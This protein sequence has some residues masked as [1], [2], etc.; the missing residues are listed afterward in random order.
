MYTIFSKSKIQVK[1]WQSTKWVHRRLRIWNRTPPNVILIGA[2]IQTT[3]LINLNIRRCNL[4]HLL[5]ELVI[6]GLYWTNASFQITFIDLT[7]F[8]KVSFTLNCS[9]KPVNLALIHVSQDYMCWR[10]NSLL[11]I[12]IFADNEKFYVVL[13]AE[14]HIFFENN[15]SKE[16]GSVIWVLFQLH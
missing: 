3:I 15:F 13:I 11:K 16:F 5:F 12:Q 14:E 8:F 1:C 4:S 6:F 2:N 9:Y 7:V 10:K